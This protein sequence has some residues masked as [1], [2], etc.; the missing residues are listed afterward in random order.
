MGDDGV[1]KEVALATSSHFQVH[2]PEQ[3][4]ENI[5]AYM[6]ERGWELIWTPRCNPRFWPLE[7]FWQHGNQYFS[8]FYETVRKLEPVREQIRQ[9]WYGDSSCSW[10]TGDWKAADCGKL[11]KHSIKEVDEW[12]ATTKSSGVAFDRDS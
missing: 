9:G 10:Q 11:V 8:L 1:N 7:L 4:L 12:V 2:H 6:K 3:L 5:E